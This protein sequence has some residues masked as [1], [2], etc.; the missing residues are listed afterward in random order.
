MDKRRK[1]RLTQKAQRQRGQ[2]NAQLTSGKVG[3]DVIGDDLSVLGA[4]LALFDGKLN[5]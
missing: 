4:L 5:L 3:V 1:R 2:R